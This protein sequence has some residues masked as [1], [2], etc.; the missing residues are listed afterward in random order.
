MKTIVIG[1]DG[2]SFEL[3]GPWIENGEL[4]NLNEIRKEGVSGDLESQPPPVTSPNWKCYSTG[5]NPGK[6]GVFWWEN[7]DW[8]ERKVYSPDYRSEENEEIWDYLNQEGRRTAVI[9][10]PTSYPPKSIDGYLVS[11]GP[12]AGDERYY[13]PKE[14]RD[15]LE[16]IDYRV[17]PGRPISDA[18]DCREIFDEILDLIE[19]RFR[20]AEELLDED[21]EI[22]FVHMT[23]FFINVLHHFLWNDELVKE[24]W[25]TIDDNIGRIMDERGDEFNLILISDHG[26]NE[27]KDVFNVNTWLEEEGLL[28]TEKGMMTG[29]LGKLGLTRSRVVNLADRLG[30]RNFLLKIL[31]DSLASSVPSSGGGVN[32]EAKGG[33]MDWEE[34]LAV[35]SG[36]GPIYLSD[37]LDEGDYEELRNDLI[38]DLEGLESPITG[39][40]I[41]RKVYKREEVYSGK[42]LDKAPDLVIDQAPNVHIP[43]ELGRG[44]VFEK[45]GKWRGENKRTGLF[46]AIGPDIRSDGGRVDVSILDI[47]PTILHIY[48]LEIPQDMDGKVLT[49]V[50][51]EGSDPAERE[52]EYRSGEEEK[53]KLKGKISELKKEGKI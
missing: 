52:V 41:V 46:A 53:K 2:A 24:A 8:S 5:K 31:P 16:K 51:A 43:G 47:A 30:V 19:K 48:G 36:Q 34:S 28:K 35:A 13:Y 10:I 11:G 7:V 22:E 3:I 18:E 15:K 38:Q 39:R 4:P 14:L 45:P 17:R 6:L 42:H 1:L 25:K 40:S 20:L 50:F 12:D 44:E 49:E 29:I 9:N 21:E 23:V 32:R 37:Q 27:I 26:S 33:M